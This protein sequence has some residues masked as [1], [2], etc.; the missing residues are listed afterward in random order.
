M[1]TGMIDI[2]CPS[3]HKRNSLLKRPTKG[4]YG[5]GHCQ[6][7]LSD[8][9][10]SS[11]LQI[12]PVFHSEKL[13]SFSVLFSI[14]LLLCCVRSVLGSTQP[15]SIS[16][17]SVISQPKSVPNSPIVIAK[18]RSLPSETTL[19]SQFMGSGGALTVSNGTN[20]D[21]YVKLVEPN[22]RTLVAA[23]YVKST[24]SFTQEQIPDG[25]YKVLFVLGK[26]WNAQTQ[27]FTKNKR[28]SKFDKLLNFTTT[29]MVGGIQYRVFKITLHPVPSGKAKTSGVSQ[30]EFNSY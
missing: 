20:S 16:S 6:S 30:K 24:S 8:P 19:V 9:F 29:Q 2:I 13:V 14:S 27:S 4:N 22:S 5:C 17:A 7:Q 21:A 1:S 28:F 3:C 10:A 18:K 15:L 23:F 25:T 12:Q 26:G 11:T